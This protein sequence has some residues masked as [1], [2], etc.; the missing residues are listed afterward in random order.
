MPYSELEEE[1]EVNMVLRTCK[2]ILTKVR[3]SHNV[4]KVIA[5]DS[6]EMT[7]ACTHT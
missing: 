2:F 1:N 5:D 6:L 4:L 3:T 7:D